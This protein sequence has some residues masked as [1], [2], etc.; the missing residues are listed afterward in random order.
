MD[1]QRSKA[2]AAFGPAFMSE[3]RKGVTFCK[4]S[5]V[6]SQEK[7]NARPIPTYAA[8]GAMGVRK[9]MSKAPGKG[10]GLI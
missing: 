7:A 3:A 4:N 6:G 10:P 8:G 5:A 9:G 1:N 2:E